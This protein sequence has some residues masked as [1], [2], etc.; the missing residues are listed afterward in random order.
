MSSFKKATPVTR[1]TPGSFGDDTG[2]WTPGQSSTLSIRMS[3]QPL[4]VD[5]IDALP[6]GQ[7]SKRAVKIYAE[8]EL[9]TADQDTGQEAD[10]IAWLGKSWEIVGC[11]PYQMGVIPHYKA[12]AVEVKD[13]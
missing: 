10:T 7:R 5:E 9:L 12:L 6:E 13:N 4:R 2:R 3:I 8:A 1:K 11:A